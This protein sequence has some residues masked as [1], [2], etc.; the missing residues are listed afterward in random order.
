MVCACNVAASR[1]FESIRFSLYSVIVYRVVCYKSS[2]SSR[3][4]AT[5]QEIWWW[6]PGILQEVACMYGLGTLTRTTMLQIKRK[7]SLDLTLQVCYRVRWILTCVVKCQSSASLR[8]C[9]AEH[10][11]LLLHVFLPLK[12]CLDNFTGSQ[13]GSFCLVDVILLSLGLTHF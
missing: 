13:S 10:R 4:R 2:L 6:W 5:N 12:K 11:L 1:M 9:I 8:A 7:I 3:K